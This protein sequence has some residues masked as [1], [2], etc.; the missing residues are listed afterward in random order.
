[1]TGSHLP[2][3]KDAHRITVPLAYDS[4]SRKSPQPAPS[5]TEQSAPRLEES[6]RTSAVRPT[7][8]MRHH[9]GSQRA[10]PAAAPSRFELHRVVR[11]HGRRPSPMQAADQHKQPPGRLPA[12]L[13]GPSA[14]HLCNPPASVLVT[15]APTG[16]GSETRSR[17]KAYGNFL[18]RRTRFPWTRSE[19]RS[20]HKAYGNQNRSN[21]T[22]P[23]PPRSETR[24]R[25]KAYGNPSEALPQR[26]RR[27]VRNEVTP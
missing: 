5:T 13:L 11:D 9:R 27:R 25:H 2:R 22:G 12:T 8:P 17:H 23:I 19:T 14:R 1:M 15:A 6:R 26:S 21:D 4:P 3:T 20:R 16:V 7:G 24:S 18:Q 10:R